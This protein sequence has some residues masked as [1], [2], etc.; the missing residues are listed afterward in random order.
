[1][2]PPKPH[3]VTH[4]AR[5]A[6]AWTALAA[7]PHTSAC[8]WDRDTLAAEAAGLPDIVDIAIGRLDRSPPAVY[9][10]RLERV[11]AQLDADPTRLGLYDDAAVAADRLADHDTAIRWM[12]RKR[13]QLNQLRDTAGANAQHLDDHEYRY[14][15][16]L[17][18]FHAHRFI[19]SHPRDNAD[20]DAAIDLIEQAI[21]LNPDAHFG[22]E[23]VQLELLITLRDAHT[24]GQPTP[25]IIDSSP[26]RN[27]PL[28]FHITGN[29]IEPE[30]LI[31]GLVGIIA[32]GDAWNS[33]DV[34]TA[35]AHALFSKHDSSLA[36]LVNLRAHEL[37]AH[38]PRSLLNTPV[39]IDEADFP[40]D[41]S[42]R[43]AFMYTPSAHED[44][45]DH[46][47]R[48]TLP[49]GN[50]NTNLEYYNTARRWAV[51]TNNQRHAHINNLLN[52][53][54]HPDTHPADFSTIPAF[55][56]RPELPDQ[57]F[58]LTSFALQHPTAATIAIVT[59]LA[60]PIPLALAAGYF[61]RRRLRRRAAASAPAT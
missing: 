51:Q 23:I 35:L 60:T 50:F 40:N 19:R 53:G 18:T 6:A 21:T 56:P 30:E 54:K 28:T 43:V 36:L 57:W 7:A 61:I 41:G 31:E 14:L 13:Q 45:N 29:T 10:Q 9:R 37:F 5:I 17:G 44:S 8:L 11:T 26:I 38:T 24:S 2:R 25:L 46:L 27:G 3:R 1:M 22:R 12:E 48:W 34:H 59:T 47:H 32:L 55:A 20:I 52:D 58:D 4:I 49:A 16:N 39:G 42:T 15:A 33:Y